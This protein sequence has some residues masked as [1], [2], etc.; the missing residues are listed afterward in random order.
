MADES[1]PQGLPLSDEEL[2]TFAGR[3]ESLALDDVPWVAG[4]LRECL[5]A[6]AAEGSWL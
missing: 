6:R 4:L 2:T 1:S 5:R 3:L